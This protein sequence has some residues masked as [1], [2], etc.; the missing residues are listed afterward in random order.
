MRIFML[1]H[2]FGCKVVCAALEELIVDIQGGKIPLAAGTQFRVV[3]MEPATDDD[4]LE[5]GDIYGRVSK[6][7]NLRLLITKSS[8]DLALGKWFP[9]AGRAV[10]LFNPRL[11][12]GSAGPTPATIAAFGG[13]TSVT[14]SGGFTP[15]AVASAQTAL[16]VADL[17]VVHEARAASGIFTGGGIAG[18]HSDIYFSEVYNL[19]SGFLFS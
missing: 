7:P 2:S 18:S 17:T 16:V 9:L 5:P 1:G 15:S 11:A 14:V 6:I 19:V 4:N 8:A 3:L 10:N 13:S 12:L